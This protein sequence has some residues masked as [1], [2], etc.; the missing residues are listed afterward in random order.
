MALICYG[1]ASALAKKY[2][3]EEGSDHLREI[4]QQVEGN[5]VLTSALTHL[6][7]VS[8]IECAKRTARIN[9]PAYRSAAAALETD[10]RSS[11]ASAD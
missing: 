9:S 5:G 3:E 11:S 2:L 6:E 4:L 1:D 10:V 8:T 7:I